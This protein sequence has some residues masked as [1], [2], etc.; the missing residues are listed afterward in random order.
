MKD[1]ANVAPIH[2]CNVIIDGVTI[3]LF[4]IVLIY[5]EPRFHP[6]PLAAWNTQGAS[7]LNSRDKLLA[8][9]F[10]D[11]NCENDDWNPLQAFR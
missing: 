8:E 10:P 11:L 6:L 5:H 1:N 9:L 7:L 4:F 3:H 2:T